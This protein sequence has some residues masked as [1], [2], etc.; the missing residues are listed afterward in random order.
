MAEKL[1]TVV[2]ASSTDRSICRPGFF[3]R[4]TPGTVHGL[5]IRAVSSAWKT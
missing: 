4:H 5:R 2:A 3:V 1:K